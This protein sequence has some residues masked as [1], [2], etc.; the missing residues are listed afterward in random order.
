MSN[1]IEILCINNIYNFVSGDYYG[2]LPEFLNNKYTMYYTC[3]ISFE[4]ISYIWDD[5]KYN[6]VCNEETDEDDKII[7]NDLHNLLFK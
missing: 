4:I 3:P 2:F 7:N 1:I 5:I 6:F